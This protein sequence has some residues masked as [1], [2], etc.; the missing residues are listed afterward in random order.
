M[1]EKKLMFW[2]FGVGVGFMLILLALST[3]NP[4]P[5]VSQRQIWQA[6]L[7]VILAAFANGI[8]GLLE[9]NINIPRLG[10]SIRALGAIAV[11]VIVYFFV[12]AFA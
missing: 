8:L 3:T 10:L 2:S 1:S 4:N 12:P 9:V 6:I 7:S 5:T 11:A